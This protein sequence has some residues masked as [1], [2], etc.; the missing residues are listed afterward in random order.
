MSRYIEESKIRAQG[1]Y[2]RSIF[3]VENIRK[4]GAIKERVLET[5][6]KFLLDEP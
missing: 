6:I 5:C 4:E 1:E 2:N 3:L